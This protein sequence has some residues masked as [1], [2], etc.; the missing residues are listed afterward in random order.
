VADFV[1]GARRADHAATEDLRHLANHGARHASSR[2]HD[3][4]LPGALDP[5]YAEEAGVRGPSRHAEDADIVGGV[6]V[7]WE[8]LGE[9]QVLARR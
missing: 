1:I 3:D 9:E 7:R 8:L 6:H 2:T 5:T 4:G